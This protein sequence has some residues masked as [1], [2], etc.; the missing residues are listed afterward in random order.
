MMIVARDTR[1]RWVAATMALNLIL[2]VQVH[3]EPLGPYDP[4]ADVPDK[5]PESL[6]AF[7]LSV[8]INAADIGASFVGRGSGPMDQ[9]IPAEVFCEIHSIFE[10]TRTGQSQ[11]F[12]NVGN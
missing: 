1:S 6:E 4:L 7:A 3:A 2:A 11:S 9:D 12:L 5:A 10:S 8:A